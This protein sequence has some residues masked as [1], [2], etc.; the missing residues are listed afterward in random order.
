MTIADPSMDGSSSRL[1]RPEHHPTDNRPGGLVRPAWHLLLDRPEPERVLVVGGVEPSVEAWLADLGAKVRRLDRAA[2]RSTPVDL[3][4]V[5]GDAAGSVGG[6]DLAWLARCCGSTGSL[7]LPGR[8]S[9]RRDRHLRELG[10]VVRRWAGP[11]RSTVHWTPSPGVVACARGAPDRPPSWLEEI[12]RRAGGNAGG[13]AWNM[14]TPRDYPSQKT[15]AHLRSRAGGGRPLV[16]KVTQH[17]RFNDRLD[18]EARRLRELEVAA[19]GAPA[20]APRAFGVTRVGGLAA[21]VEERLAGR[22]FLAVSRLAPDCGWAV[23]AVAA[24]TGVGQ[25]TRTVGPGHHLAE[26]ISPL[27][28]PFIVRHRPP[29]AVAAFLRS[30]VEV[31]AAAPEVPAVMFHGDLGTWNLM[32]VDGRV[33]ILDWESAEMPGPPLW[34]LVYL[35]RSYAVRSGRRHGRGRD[36]A[37]T[38]HL[39]EGSSLTTAFD[40]WIR[41]YCRT[42]GLPRDLVAPLF[43]TCWMHRAVKEATRL[44]TDQAGHYGP[45]CIRLVE[46]RSAPGLRRLLGG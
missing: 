1:R 3:V 25:A 33:R 7:W 15:V 16:V 24:I 43:H 13:G 27:V 14:S 6:S 34:D 29:A 19:R 22:P 12:G 10:F 2:G 28:E 21:V 11:G 31:L 41:H 42:L 32:V 9:S 20:R 4:I 39:L 26:M 23:D 44:R 46:G 18:N 17:P 36:R 45:L 5:G 8:R 40:G 35:L 38:R 37:I 30:Q